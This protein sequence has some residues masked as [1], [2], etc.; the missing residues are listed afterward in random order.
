MEC[1]NILKYSLFFLIIVILATILNKNK[2]EKK[3]IKIL[4]ILRNN[5]LNGI[6]N[7]GTNNFVSIKNIL[8]IIIK[9]TK[10]NIIAKTNNISFSDVPLRKVNYSKF[11][12]H[13]KNFN[14]EKISSG[15][16]K[17]INWYKSKSHD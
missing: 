8:D 15:L 17:T 12:K 3:E 2:M 16:L 7:V 10:S 6:I 5:N 13:I 4:M 11:K 14:F 9:S 1:N